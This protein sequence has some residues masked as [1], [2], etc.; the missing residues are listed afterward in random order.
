M[1]VEINKD[2]YYMHNVCGFNFFIT[3]NGKK[4]IDQ[5]GAE[6]VNVAENENSIIPEPVNPKY[7][8]AYLDLFN[9]LKKYFH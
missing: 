4:G 9:D 7:L 6:W 8:D 2:P 1:S 5:H 3:F